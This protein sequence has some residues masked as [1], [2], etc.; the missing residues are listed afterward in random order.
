MVTIN[1]EIE[2]N[3]RMF[4]LMLINFLCATNLQHPHAFAL[5]PKVDS[6]KK[7]PDFNL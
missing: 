1:P 7:E 5:N 2:P 3:R 4:F 6:I